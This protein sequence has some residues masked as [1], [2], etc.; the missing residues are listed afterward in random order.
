MSYLL[1][2]SSFGVVSG[3]PRGEAPLVLLFERDDTMAVPLLS[4]LRVAGYDVRAA[5]TPVDLFDAAQKH[6]VALIVVDLNNA[7]AA[8]REFWVALDA[9]RR[10]RATQVLTFRV[11]KA[12]DPYPADLEAAAHALADLEVGGPREVALLVEAV[13]QRVPLGASPAGPAASPMGVMGMG[14]TGIPAHGTGI[15]SSPW[16]QDPSSP[17]ASPAPGNPFSEAAS[18]SP[19]DLPDAMNPFA[20]TQPRA[21][22][23]NQPASLEAQASESYGV[24]T[25]PPAPGPIW[26]QSNPAERAGTFAR[27]PAIP[28]L[29]TEGY[30]AS[31]SNAS[32]QV[33]GLAATPWQT[34]VP[35]RT[36]NPGYVPAGADSLYSP[37]SIADAWTPP[38]GAVLSHEALSAGATDMRHN[39][40]PCEGQTAGMPEPGDGFATDP[41]I[42]SK[43]HQPA[44]SLADPTRQQ[45]VAEELPHAERSTSPDVAEAAQVG[46]PGTTSG[47]ALISPEERALGA[48][49]VEG[50][51]LSSQRLEVLGEIRH[52]LTS[53]DVNIKLGE[54]ALLF[55][56]LSPDQLLAALLVS[57]RLITPEQIAAL[58]RIKQEMG[59][60]G[61]NYDLESLLVM[62]NI[63]SREDLERL[64]GELA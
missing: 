50:A 19:F 49:L 28:A 35:S 54:L 58:G 47:S 41:R 2:N 39:G 46:A 3:G 59:A 51:L 16:R 8:R 48:V 61:I 15:A 29:P 53:V 57:R 34:A 10:G 55:R 4:Q 13:S 17:F 42:F 32:G 56:F 5:R 1:P 25:L 44:N 40:L 45:F 36:S 23:A 60:S 14:M 26:T 12:N 31:A 62:F 30:P 43:G 21:H 20:Q 27:I 38:D 64:R 33:N 11:V 63:M 52:M 6:A 24:P 22:L 18:S 9:Q 37:P 7:A